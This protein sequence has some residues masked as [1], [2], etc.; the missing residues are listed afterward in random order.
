[1]LRLSESHGVKRTDFIQ[2]YQGAELDPNWMKSIS[3]LTAKGWK[4]FYRVE[5]ETIKA[6]RAEIQNLATETGIS[7]SEFR[8]IVHMVQKGEREAGIA[9]KEMVEANLRL[10]ISNRQ[11]IHQSRAAVP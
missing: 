6:I 3:N 7:I 5:K 8:R 11:E 2:Q 4:E 9:K 1:M 10:V